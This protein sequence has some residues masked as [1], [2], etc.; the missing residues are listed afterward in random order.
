MKLDMTVT[1]IKRVHRQ[2]DRRF[3]RTRSSAVFCGAKIQSNTSRVKEIYD[4]AI[5][6][7]CNGKRRNQRHA[8]RAAGQA[9]MS[10]EFAAVRF[11]P[12]HL[13]IVTPGGPIAALGTEKLVQHHVL[14]LLRES[15]FT[16]EPQQLSVELQPCHRHARLTHLGYIR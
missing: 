12:L 4:N 11:F 15:S 2:M 9:T 10:V 13:H 16:G 14:K 3:A 7:S 1:W 8:T 6:I 5:R